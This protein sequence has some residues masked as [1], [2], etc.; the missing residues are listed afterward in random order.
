[1]R[2][3][4]MEVVGKRN[5]VAAGPLADTLRS[6]HSPREDYLCISRDQRRLV[7]GARKK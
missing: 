7:I 6:G 1:M 5:S 3:V 2:A 4:K